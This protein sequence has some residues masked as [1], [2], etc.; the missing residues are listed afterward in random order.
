M[1]DG[2]G[3][4]G[5]IGE[6]AVPQHVGKD[7]LHVVGVNCRL[8]VEKC[9]GAGRSLQGE[10]SAHRNG[11][12]LTCQGSG[13]LAESEEITLQIFGDWK[14]GDLFLKGDKILEAQ[15]AGDLLLTKGAVAVESEDIELTVLRGQ[16][17]WDGEQ[18]TVKL[19]FGKGKGSGGR[20]V[21]L[22]GHYQK[23]IGE[24]F[25]FSVDG[26]LPFVH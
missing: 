13:R 22:G 15:D 24:L 25:C 4:K 8:A 7:C 6:E 18:E 5:V 26:N 12:V 1:E 2:V 20:G 11:V 16:G 23:G 19:G 3:I 17:H 9:V 10:R 21:V 14:T